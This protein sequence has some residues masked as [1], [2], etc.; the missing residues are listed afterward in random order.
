MSYPESGNDSL[1]V[2]DEYG[3]TLN[4]GRCLT[5]TYVAVVKGALS[6]GSPDKDIYSKE[7]G[8]AAEIM[9]T[10]TVIKN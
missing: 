6:N 7:L 10:L 2:A 1:F 4:N 9:S 3:Y 8:V 5:F